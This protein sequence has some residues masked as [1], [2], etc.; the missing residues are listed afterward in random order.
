MTRS[1]YITK[2]QGLFWYTPK[3]KLAD[4]SDSFLVETILNYGSLDDVK[5]LFRVM[6]IKNA[7]KVF[8][9]SIAL[10]ERRKNNYHE[11]TLNYFTLLF[12]QYAH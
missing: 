1:E 9:D 11:L 5:E 6:G 3:D 8:F 7:A 12:D 4:I 10:S 2:H